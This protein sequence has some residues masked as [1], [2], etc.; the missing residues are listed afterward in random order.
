MAFAQDDIDDDIDDDWSPEP[1]T[2]ATYIY[3]LLR[4]KSVV[5]VGIGYYSDGRM[6]EHWRKK[7]LHFDD[8]IETPDSPYCRAEAERREKILIPCFRPEYNQK[9]KFRRITK[10]E[11]MEFLGWLSRWPEGNDA[12]CA[13][14]E[15]ILRIDLALGAHAY[16]LFCS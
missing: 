12:M 5:Y 4:N 10:K 14:I 6:R 7:G 1:P 15:R 13:R 2:D 8:M 11:E 3:L 9:H 16:P